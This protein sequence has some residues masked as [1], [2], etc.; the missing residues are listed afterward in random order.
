[1]DVNVRRTTAEELFRLR[2]DGLRHELVAGAL[3]TMAPSGGEHGWVTSDLHESLSVHVRAQALGRVF[4]AETGFL[5][6]MNPDTVRAPDVAFVRRERVLAVG[7]RPGYW[8]GAP[9]RAIA[10]ISPHDRPHEVAEQVATWLRYGTLMIVAVDPRR[11]TA[12]VHRLGQPVRVLDEVDTLDGDDVVPGWH[13][14][15]QWLFAEN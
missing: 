14:S 3:R 10:V 2:D 7:R 9:D 11:R 12:A 6:A 5:L 13:L 15:L 1:M 4:A 8:P